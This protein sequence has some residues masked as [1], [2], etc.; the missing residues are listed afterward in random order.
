MRLQTALTTDAHHVTT[1]LDH[2]WSCY[3]CCSAMGAAARPDYCWGSRPQE[4][5]L[6]PRRE[7]LVLLRFCTDLFFNWLICSLPIAALTGTGA[8]AGSRL[9]PT[10]L[11]TKQ[12]HQPVDKLGKGLSKPQLKRLSQHCSKNTQS[13]RPVHNHPAPACG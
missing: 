6:L 10:A 13:F 2:I 9:R 5:L 1:R 7:P 3:H 4:Q 11:S 8:D 12:V